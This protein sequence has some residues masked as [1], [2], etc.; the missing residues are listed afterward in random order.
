MRVWNVE[1]L[2]KRDK[3]WTQLGNTASKCF[4]QQAE[5]AAAKESTVVNCSAV[6]DKQVQSPNAGNLLK[7]PTNLRVSNALGAD[8]LPEDVEDQVSKMCLYHVKLGLLE[9]LIVF[10]LC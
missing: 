8:S 7:V 4:S 10:D 6:L 3:V 5:S 2:G 9:D 1:R